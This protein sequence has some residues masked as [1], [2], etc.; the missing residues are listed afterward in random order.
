ML[1]LATDREIFVSIFS[2]LTSHDD[3]TDCRES[4]HGNDGE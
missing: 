1:K 4:R 2:F 3:E